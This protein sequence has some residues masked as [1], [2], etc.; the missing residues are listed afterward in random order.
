LGEWC[1]HP[2]INSNGEVL[3]YKSRKAGHTSDIIY[4]NLKTETKI[5]LTN[6]SINNQHS[7]RLSNNGTYL[8]YVSSETRENT[9]FDQI[10]VMDLSNPQKPIKTQVTFDGTYKWDP[11]FGSSGEHIYY[12]R[13]YG[14]TKENSNLVNIIKGENLLH[15]E[16]KSQNNSY[17]KTEIKPIIKKQFTK[18]KYKK[19]KKKKTYKKS[20]K[21]QK[22]P[23]RRGR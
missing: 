8:T 20:F 2:S 3:V 19:R 13:T 21:K 1:E 22:K 18:P 4:L 5:N 9:G 17:K 12:G 14:D 23:R 11:T 10:F 15:T 16:N 7:P 6:D